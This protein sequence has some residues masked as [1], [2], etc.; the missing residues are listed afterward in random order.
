M[1]SFVGGRQVRTYGHK[2]ANVPSADKGTLAHYLWVL[3]VGA[4]HKTRE[5]RAT[6]TASFISECQAAV[7]A[8]CFFGDRFARCATLCAG[9]CSPFGFTM[10]SINSFWAST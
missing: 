9:L 3:S 7:T 10:T 6:L 8:A 1:G 4:R 5:T 2:L